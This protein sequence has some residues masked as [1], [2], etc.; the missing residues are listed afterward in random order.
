MRSRIAD[1]GSKEASEN[2]GSGRRIL[3][4]AGVGFGLLF[5]NFEPT[6]A[7]SPNRVA[8]ERFGFAAARFI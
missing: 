5:S 3:N 8:G 1:K 6:N 4:R 7:R 2:N